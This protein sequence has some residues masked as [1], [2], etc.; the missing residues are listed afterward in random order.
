MIIILEQM[1][2]LEEAVVAELDQDLEVLVIL[3]QQTHLKEMMVVQVVQVYHN[4]VLVVEEEL[5]VQVLARQED[6]QVEQEVQEYLI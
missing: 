1:E 4:Q 2:D 6:I 3:P 5:V